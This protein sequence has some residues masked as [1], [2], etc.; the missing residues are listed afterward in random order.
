MYM[1]RINGINLY[2][3]EICR[4]YLNLDDDGNCY[5]ADGPGCYRRV[6]FESQLNKLKESLSAFNADLG[7][8]YD[9]GFIARKTEEL[10]QHG[11]FLLTIEVEPADVL[12]H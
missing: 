7:T 12:I 2:K 3:H 6:D 4:D 5:I 1:G 9:E 10:R 11:I 8:P